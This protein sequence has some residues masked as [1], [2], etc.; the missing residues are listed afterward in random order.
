MNDN[1]LIMSHNFIDS[2]SIEIKII[3]IQN[4]SMSDPSLSDIYFKQEMGLNKP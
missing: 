4:R 2:K 3:Q 1:S